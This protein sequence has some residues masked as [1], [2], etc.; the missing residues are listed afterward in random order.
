MAQ[1]YK[2]KIT[3][4]EYLRALA[5]FTV[6]HGHYV[7]SI[8]FSKALNKIIMTAPEKYLGGH[9]DDLLYSEF[10]G[11]A[12]EFD[13]ALKRED[14]QVEKPAAAKKKRARR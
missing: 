1:Y 10:S 5:L 12:A 11:T 9:V 7:Q 4:D 13:E 6:A 8:T 2:P 14:V 3:H